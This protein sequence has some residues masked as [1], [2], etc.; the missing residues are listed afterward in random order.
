M[1]MDKFTTWMLGVFPNWNPEK[2]I[3]RIWADELPEI[4]AEQAI[5][6]VRKIMKENPSPFPPSV[7]EIKNKLN[8]QATPRNE[9]RLIFN[10][11]WENQ[12]NLCPD[13]RELI[14]SA[15]TK[16][17][18]ALFGG[19]GQLLESEKQWAEKRFIEIY[20]SLTEMEPTLNQNQ[21]EQPQ[22]F[23]KLTNG[24]RVNDS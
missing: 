7:F 4:K 20:E 18:L 8:G 14:N 22:V 3:T 12:K 5:E 10:A 23:L 19:F 16:K 21:L 1:E 13:I 6:A 15:K 9:G 2:S 11:V 24:D 17:A